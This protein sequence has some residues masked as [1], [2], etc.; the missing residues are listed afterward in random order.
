MAMIQEQRCWSCR[1]CIQPSRA[2]TALILSSTAIMTA[3]ILMLLIIR[4]SRQRR[5][6]AKVSLVFVRVIAT[7]KALLLFLVIDKIHIPNF[8]I[9]TVQI[10]IVVS[11]SQDANDILR[12]VCHDLEIDHKDA[13]CLIVSLICHDEE[14]RVDLIVFLA[15]LNVVFIDIAKSE[16]GEVGCSYEHRLTSTVFDLVDVAFELLK[17]QIIECD[18]SVDWP[19]LA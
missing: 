2:S 10:C 7:P 3:N 18:Q 9:S 11:A 13:F 15:K 4:R 12:S 5:I 16:I 19:L 6:F 17:F 8:K 14:S 1:Q